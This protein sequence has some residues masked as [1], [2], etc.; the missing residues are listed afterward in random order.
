MS[1]FL[2]ILFISVESFALKIP[3]ESYVFK[4]DAGKI[5][6][7]AI[8]R[9]SALKIRGEGEGP[10]GEVVVDKNKVVN[11][12]LTFNLESLKTGIDMRDQH[13]K[14]KYL[15]TNEHPKAEFILKNIQL[16]ESAELEVPGTLKLHGK[17]QLVTAKIRFQEKSDGISMAAK[18]PVKLGE[19]GIDIPNYLG[20]KVAEDVEV[21]VESLIAVK[22]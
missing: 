7:L 13:M 18:F 21:E 2:L 8:G 15:Q 19:F 22:K 16:A 1:Y 5:K 12:K 11:G 14:E 17:E 4:P 10:S 3:A 9:P 20:I 6:F